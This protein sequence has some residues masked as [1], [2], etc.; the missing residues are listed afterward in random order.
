DRRARVVAGGAAVRRTRA[1]APGAPDHVRQHQH[2]HVAA[3]AVTLSGDPVEHGEHRLAEAGVAIVDLQR[4]GPPWKIRVAPMGE[5]A[6][7]EPR[8]RAYGV[9]RL[10]REVLVGSV[11]VELWMLA[12]P[13]LSEG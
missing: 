7:A 12:H 10:A 5:H 11:N 3:H 8:V 1:I 4:V 6:R 13:G 9:L 2:G